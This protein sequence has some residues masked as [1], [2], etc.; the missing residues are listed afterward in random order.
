MDIS[1][2]TANTIGSIAGAIIGGFVSGGNPLGAA[3][4]SVAG[5]YLAD[6]FT[7][8]QFSLSS[9]IG[10]AAGAA[11]GGAVIG[12]IAGG[13]LGYYGDSAF[14]SYATSRRNVTLPPATFLRGAG[15]ITT[16]TS[17]PTLV[18]ISITPPL[19]RLSQKS[20]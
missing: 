1:Q 10:H 4:G 11:I 6:L 18:S 7:G 12:G 8:N 5:E 20:F 15:R 9:A 2:N 19:L 17:R 14:N 3:A 16:S 13:A